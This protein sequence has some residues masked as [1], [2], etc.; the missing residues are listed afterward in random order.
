MYL[1]RKPYIVVNEYSFEIESISFMRVGEM[2]IVRLD[3]YGTPCK[4]LNSGSTIANNSEIRGAG[5]HIDTLI[6]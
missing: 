4:A 3:L 2:K 5:E 1:K 6:C